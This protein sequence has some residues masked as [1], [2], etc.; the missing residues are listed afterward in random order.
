MKLTRLRAVVFVKN[1]NLDLT[2]KS[3]AGRAA[4]ITANSAGLAASPMVLKHERFTNTFPRYLE[5]VSDNHLLPIEEA[6]RRITALPA[7]KLGIKKRGIVAEGAFA[8]LVL[9]SRSPQDAFGVEHVFV[10]GVLVVRAKQCQ[11]V[12]AGKILTRA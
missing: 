7:Q 10:N 11:A 12:R 6:I 3:F 5:L 9:F 4:L 1:V 8:D 2:I